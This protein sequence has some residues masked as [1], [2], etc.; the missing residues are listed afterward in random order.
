MGNRVDEAV[1]LLITANFADQKNRVENE[2]GNDDEKKYAAEEKFE[3][4]APVEDDP[5]DVQRERRR[6]QANAQRDEEVDGLLPADDPHRKKV[7]P[8]GSQI[9]GVR[10]QEGQRQVTGH[11]EPG[12]ALDIPET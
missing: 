1:V 8:S 5:A 7:S 3:A 6:N 12:L 2:A 10:S 11:R 4:F 9:L